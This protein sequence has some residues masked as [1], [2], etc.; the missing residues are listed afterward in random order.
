MGGAVSSTGLLV[1]CG[2]LFEQLRYS[3]GTV[4]GVWNFVVWSG[5]CALLGHDSALLG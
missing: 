4:I 2:F 3:H 1:Q 5:S